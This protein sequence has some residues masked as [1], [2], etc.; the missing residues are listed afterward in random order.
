MKIFNMITKKEKI[1][2][3]N[4]ENSEGGIY[5][6]IAMAKRIQNTMKLLLKDNPY[7]PTSFMFQGECLLEKYKR[8]VKEQLQRDIDRGAALLN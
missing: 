6:D 4:K 2:K 7:L 3:M 8:E 1:E 5:K